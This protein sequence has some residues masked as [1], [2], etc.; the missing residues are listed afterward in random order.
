MTKAYN[1]I[2]QKLTLL[3][4]TAVEDKLQDQVPQTIEAL[5]MAGIKVT[6][7][8]FFLCLFNTQTTVALFDPIYVVWIMSDNTNTDSLLMKLRTVIECSGEFLRILVN[9][10]TNN[11]LHSKFWCDCK[12]CQ[13]LVFD[14]WVG[15]LVT[16]FTL[17]SF[18]M[19]Q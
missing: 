16:L 11:N 9:S 14:R 3:G 7:I 5:R 17:V 12:H 15:K 6:H 1:E 13:C 8:L 4:A 19:G 2:E 10:T 18:N